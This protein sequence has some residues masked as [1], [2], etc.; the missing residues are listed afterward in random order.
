M[1]KISRLGGMSDAVLGIYPVATTVHTSTVSDMR[2]GYYSAATVISTVHDVR[3]DVS[4]QVTGSEE[5]AWPAVGGDST[6]P[7][8]SESSSK[9]SGEVNPFLRA[10][11]TESLSSSDLTPFGSADTTDSASPSDK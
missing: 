11:T 1:A 5:E 7:T 10:P 3:D 9:P 2:E 8:S 4:S 6:T